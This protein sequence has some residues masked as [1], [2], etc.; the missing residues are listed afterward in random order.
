MWASAMQ[1]AQQ[2]IKQYRHKRIFICLTIALLA[3]FITLSLRFISQRSLNQQRLQTAATHAVETLDKVLLPLENQR[4]ELLQL[5]GLSCDA[6]SLELRKQAAALQ[7]VRSIAL[8]QSGVLYCSSVLGVRNLVLGETLPELPSES[9]QLLLTTDKTLT[10]GRPLLVRW[11]PM[12]KDPTSGVLITINIDLLSALMLEPEK[13]LIDDVSLTVG[14]RHLSEHTDV[15]NELPMHANES[16]FRLASHRFPFT[17]NITGPGTTEMALSTLPTQL[18]L[19]LIAGLLAAGIAWLVT[20]S[21]MSFSWEINMGIASREFDIWCQPLLN[22]GNLKCIGVEILLR[23]NNPRLGQVSPDVFI[24]LAEE[25]NLI[26]SLTRYVISETVRQ[27]HVFPASPQFHVGFN[28]AS[29]HFVGG[30][31]LRD[32]NKH[33]FSAHPPQQLVLELTERD[34]L[35]DVDYRLVREL[36]RKDIKLAIDDFGTGNSSF[37]WL[38]KLRPDVLKIDKSFTHAIGTDA[39]NSTVMDI[40]IAL[41]QR[42]GIELVAEGVETPEQAQYLRQHGVHVLQGFLYARPMPLRDFP[43]WLAGNQPP[44]RQHSGHPVPHMPMMH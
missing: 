34:A 14:H 25:H 38:E 5:V 4:A 2:A 40:I 37:A 13:P 16:I 33:W 20:A 7:T 12:D 28:V 30:A 18:P 43:Q 10:T 31:L 32:L 39:V 17:V 19:A 1:T 35:H 27:I 11:Y 29:S 9:P 26:S 3:V 44:P 6:V 24:P 42:L 41:G 23:W 15:V 22:A 36:H 21:R 8:V